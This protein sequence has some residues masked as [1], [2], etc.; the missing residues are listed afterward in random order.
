M[1]A[2]DDDD[3]EQQQETGGVSS[4]PVMSQPIQS[5]ALKQQQQSVMD[6]FQSQWDKPEFLETFYSFRQNYSEPSFHANPHLSSDSE[7]RQRFEKALLVLKDTESLQ[8][9]FHGTPFENVSSILR[10]GLYPALR[11]GQKFGPGE[12]FSF[13]PF[14]AAKYS[15]SNSSKW[16]PN[17]E[18]KCIVVCVVILPKRPA[19]THLVIKNPNHR[20]PIGIMQCVK[21]NEN[22]RQLLERRYS[23]FHKRLQRYELLEEQIEM[24][25]RQILLDLK[26]KEP[27][28]ASDLYRRFADLLKAS[29]ESK[30]EIL[31]EVLARVSAREFPE[32]FI[33]T[34]FPGLLLESPNNNG[35]ASTTGGSPLAGGIQYRH[36][37]NIPRGIFS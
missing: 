2:A 23:N 3:D 4:I 17:G 7:C 21:I 22:Q 10:Y 15:S 14:I 31:C 24:I 25:K 16:C 20:I 6:Y 27:A 30:A 26:K 34:Q 18:I 36:G 29:P 5:S 9:A 12:Y 8:V 37:P 13:D 33:A 28:M 1:V 11:H 35:A 32:S 19:E